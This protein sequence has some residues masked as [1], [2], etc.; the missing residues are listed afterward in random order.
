MTCQIT[1]SATPVP[2]NF[3]DVAFKLWEGWQEG[4][5]QPDKQSGQYFVNKKTQPINHVGE[6]FQVQGPLNITRSPQGRPVIIEAGS[7]SDGQKTCR[8]DRR[9][10]FHR[11]SK[12]GRSAGFLSVAKITG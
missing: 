12:S 5:V 7:S 3:L 8:R 9:G 11:C 6:H 4:A 10:Y 2:V 1:P